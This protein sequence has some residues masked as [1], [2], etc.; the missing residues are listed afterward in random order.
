LERALAP[1]LVSS[2][3]QPIPWHLFLRL[4]PFLSLIQH[5]C[6]LVNVSVVHSCT[7]PSR[8]PPTG[9]RPGIFPRLFARLPSSPPELPQFDVYQT[10]RHRDKDS[11]SIPPFLRPRLF[12][13]SKLLS[14]PHRPLRT[15]RTSWPRICSLF[16][17][18]LENPAVT[19]SLLLRASLTPFFRS[20]QTSTPRSFSSV[21]RPIRPFPALSARPPGLPVR[22]LLPG[23]FSWLSDLPFD[24]SF[25]DSLFRSASDSRSR[26]FSF[27]HRAGAVYSLFPCPPFVSAFLENQPRFC[28]SFCLKARG[29]SAP[30]SFLESTLCLHLLTFFLPLVS[31]GSFLFPCSDRPPAFVCLRL[32]ISC[33][34]FS[35]PRSLPSSFPFPFPEV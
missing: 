7:C 30:A 14:F 28:S 21:N 6:L 29:L 20:R 10:A 18:P 15:L 4:F 11:L 17:P 25:G 35:G 34:F 31:A 33:L 32:R 1:V 2:S 27:V 16:P 12:V 22:S 9:F 23:E 13:F 5:P 8:P 3:P 24:F 19:P 26:Y